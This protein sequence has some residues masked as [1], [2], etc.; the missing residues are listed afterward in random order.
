[1]R[2]RGGRWDRFFV[3]CECDAEKTPGCGIV[4][5]LADEIAALLQLAKAGLHG[6]LSVVAA[7]HQVG[8]A[9]LP[10]VGTAEHVGHQALGLPG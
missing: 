7:A 4:A 1:M 8:H 9:D 3:D 5:P 10:A 2:T 6:V